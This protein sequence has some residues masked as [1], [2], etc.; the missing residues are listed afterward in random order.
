MKDQILSA[1]GWVEGCLALE[2]PRISAVEGRALSR[3]TSPRPP[4]IVPG[5]IDLHVHGG[6]GADWTS[7]EAGIR[8]FVR[9]HT[10]HGTTAIAPTTATGP[11][12]VIER[13]LAAIA[14]V[15]NGR[16]VG[17]AVVLGAHLEGPFVNPKRPGAMNGALMLEGDAELARRWAERY[18]IAVATVAPEIAG[19]RGVLEALAQTGCRVQI[20]HSVATPDEIDRAFQCGCSGFTHLF[21]AMTEVEH[22]APGVAA[23]AMAKAQY[24]EIIC[25]MIHVDPIVLLAARR[26]IPC[27]YAIT[28]ASAAGLPDGELEWGGNRVIK[29][30]G[31]VT[32]TDGKTPRG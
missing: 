13:S 26:A 22:R 18:R 7:G 14:S 3:G 6:G 30:G 16:E 32:L 15:A 28:D 31:R 5:F 24:A 25:D 27:L 2:G 17:E 19:G 23:Y 1:E 21:N 4:Y 20:G 8:T 9:Y 12:S 11:V 29:R 10:A